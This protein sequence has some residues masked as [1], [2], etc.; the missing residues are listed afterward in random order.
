MDLFILYKTNYILF[1]YIS[2]LKLNHDRIEYFGT[3]TDSNHLITKN[4]P[5][6]VVDIKTICL[7]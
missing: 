5:F 4:D 2:A 7:A 1:D 3:P 6:A